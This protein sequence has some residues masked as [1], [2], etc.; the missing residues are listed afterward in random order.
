MDVALEVEESVEEVEGEE[1][2]SVDGE[3]GIEAS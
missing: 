2:D 3:E 1:E